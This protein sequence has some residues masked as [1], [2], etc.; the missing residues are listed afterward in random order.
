MFAQKT[1]VLA[2]AL[3]FTACNADELFM[4]KPNPMRDAGVV[5]HSA[6]SSS[7]A[8]GLIET[9]DA[10][11][12]SSGGAATSGSAEI[13][14][15][16]TEDTASS[17]SMTGPTGIFEYKRHLT[18]QTDGT[19]HYYGQDVLLVDGQVLSADASLGFRGRLPAGLHTFIIAPINEDRLG[20]RAWLK[21][22]IEIRQ[23]AVTLWQPLKPPCLRGMWLR[24]TSTEVS[25]GMQPVAPYVDDQDCQWTITGFGR[26]LYVNGFSLGTSCRSAGT[27]SDF[28][29]A[30][31]VSSI[32]VD[33]DRYTPAGALDCP[34]LP[35]ELQ[36]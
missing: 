20:V 12:T 32:E 9:A 3:V 6:T 2:F 17:S 27:D 1:S 21:E 13:N 16:S 26:D 31:D 28:N 14:S 25:V 36:P 15:S 34:P 5:D 24:G 4:V 35:S 11:A 22:R 33:N 29:I 19:R 7:S 18:E 8:S 23:D 30:D 10:G